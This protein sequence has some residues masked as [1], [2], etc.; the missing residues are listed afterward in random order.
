MNGR[1]ETTQDPIS[2]GDVSLDQRQKLSFDVEKANPL[3]QSFKLFPSVAQI[4][5][6]GITLRIIIT[7]Q[8]VG[9]AQ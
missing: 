1:H 5:W 8:E 9:Y 3:N 2:K 4:Q 6:S 7:N